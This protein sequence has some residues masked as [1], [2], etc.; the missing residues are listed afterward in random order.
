MCKHLYCFKH[1]VYCIV[2]WNA[3][4]NVYLEYFYK[5]LR[6]SLHHYTSII[7]H[8]NRHLCIKVTSCSRHFT[9]ND[10]K[11]VSL[12]RVFHCSWKTNLQ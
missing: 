9:Y 5:Q 4:Y 12:A 11:L 10:K 8:K 7:S 2:C 1:S 6:V 3:M